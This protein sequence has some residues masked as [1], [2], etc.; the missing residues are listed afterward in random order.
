MKKLLSFILIAFFTLWAS[1]NVYAFGWGFDSGGSSG[2]ATPG[3]SAGDIQTNSGGTALGGITPGT[4]VATALA[5]AVNTTGGFATYTGYSPPL[6]VGLTR[7]SELA[8][9]FG[10]ARAY[11]VVHHTVGAE[12]FAEA[13]G[14]MTINDTTNGA[15]SFSKTV[16]MGIEAGATYMVTATFSAVT[17]PGTGF[18]VSLGGVTGTTFIP[19]VGTL[20]W[21]IKA[22]AADTTDPVFSQVASEAVNYVLSSVSVKKV[23]NAQIIIGNNSGATATKIIGLP[24]AVAGTVVSKMVI[25]AQTIQLRPNG[26][27]TFYFAATNW[28]GATSCT[29]A[30]APWACCTGAGAG[31]TCTGGIISGTV[32]QTAIT[33]GCEVTGYWDLL[34]QNGSWTGN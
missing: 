34:G 1:S 21:Y 28:A 26:T 29:A 22:G 19:T 13:A 31:A 30:G 23:P 5:T 27:D 24:P 25:A 20:V 8:A 18:R 12:Y 2:S 7:G 17:T 4:G 32:R 33:L 16:A 3:G 11:T 10:A 9:A 6:A 14:T 15:N